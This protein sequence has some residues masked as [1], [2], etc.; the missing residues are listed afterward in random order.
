MVFTMI[1]Q[2]FISNENYKLRGDIKRIKLHY[3]AFDTERAFNYTTFESTNRLNSCHAEYENYSGRIRWGEIA[4]LATMY[5][6]KED[7]LIAFKSRVFDFIEYSDD[8]SMS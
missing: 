1:S 5:A 3:I 4:A 2:N 8:I 7:S 6:R